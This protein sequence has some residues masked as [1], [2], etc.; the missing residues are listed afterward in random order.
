MSEGILFIIFINKL[1][2]KEKE[3]APN[4]PKEESKEESKILAV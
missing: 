4:P 2:I 3:S 1:E